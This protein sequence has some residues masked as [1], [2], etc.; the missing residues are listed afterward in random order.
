MMTGNSMM[1]LRCKTCD[2]LYIPPKYLC[3]ECAQESLE[4][5]PVGGLGVIYSFTTIRVSPEKFKDHVP[6]DLAIVELSEG[7]RVT[8]RL[9][10]RQGESLAI[11]NPVRFVMRDNSGYWF[12]T[13]N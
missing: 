5:Y 12:E 4:E 3:A 7:I 11:G 9:K 6:Y 1:I 13:C 8:V 2:S 10:R